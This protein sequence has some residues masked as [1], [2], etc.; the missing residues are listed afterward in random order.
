MHCNCRLV[1]CC[2][3]V[4]AGEGREPGAQDKTRLATLRQA[5][6]NRTR[7]R[8]CFLSPGAS[9]SSELA[10]VVCPIPHL[11][12]H[13]LRRSFVSDL[14]DSR[15]DVSQVQQPAGHA[16]VQTTLRYDRRPEHAKRKAAELLHGPFEPAPCVARD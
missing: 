10:P 11:S 16:N 7:N 6:G 3:Q 5:C 14:L 13:D 12:P 4:S 15:D 1:S 2:G 9:Q 8:P